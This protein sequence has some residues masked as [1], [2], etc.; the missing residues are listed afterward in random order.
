MK[1]MPLE[2]RYLIWKV[3]RRLVLFNANDDGKCWHAFDVQQFF[4]PAAGASH[5]S[6]VDPLSSVIW[7]S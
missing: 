6:G 7:I 3:Y 2:D 4:L 1:V 5:G